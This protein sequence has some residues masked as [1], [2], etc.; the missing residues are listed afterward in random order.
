MSKRSVTL[1]IAA[2]A[3][4]AL[5]ALGSPALAKD[6]DVL[7]RGTCT[8]KSTSK[9]KLS[10]ENGRIEVEFEVDQNRVGRVWAVAVRR[11]GVVVSRQT[12]VTRAPS[13][14]FTARLLLANRAGTDRISA[15]ATSRSGETCRAAASF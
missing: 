12:K 6:G 13:G 11:N 4:L 5:L 1:T 15:T 10:A 14:S 8:G 3:A 7:V 9:L 2:L